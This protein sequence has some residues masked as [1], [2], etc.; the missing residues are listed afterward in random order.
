MKTKPRHEKEDSD[1]ETSSDDQGHESDRE[2]Q[3]ALEKGLLKTD[4]LNYIVETKRPPI[5]NETAILA[6]VASFKNNLDWV[7]RMDVT[8]EKD[9]PLPDA[10]EEAVDN[11]FDREIRFYKQAQQAVEVALRRLVKLNV[12]VFRPDDYY[13]EMVKSDQHMTKVRRNLLEVQQ[14]KEKQEAVR[15]L[16]EEKK[17]ASK[18]QKEVLAG[19]QNEKKKLLEAVKKHRK[20]MTAQLDQMLD[21]ARNLMQTEND[22]DEPQDRKTFP[23]RDG[24][25]M[26]GGRGGA[27]GGGRISGGAKSRNYR[28]QQYGFGGQKKR[29]KRNDSKSFGEDSGPGM[30]GRS[31]GGRGG[32]GRGGGGRGGG[33]R[34]RGGSRGRGGRRN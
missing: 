31:F 4:R 26:S 13:A 30:R 6:K 21:N 28:D 19:R 20:G 11:D 10:D 9:S 22:D 7:E 3:I 27:R 33:G 12:P 18:V 2:L 23:K 24:G 25:R 5:N 8:V 29:G 15:R 16:R 14:G 17:F 32:G 34:G 1:A